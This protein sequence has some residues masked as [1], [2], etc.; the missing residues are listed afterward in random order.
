MGLGKQSNISHKQCVC[1][2]D[3]HDKNMF[4][5]FPQWVSLTLIGLSTN[6]KEA[7]WMGHW[8]DPLSRTSVAWKTATNMC[9]D[10]KSEAKQSPADKSFLSVSLRSFGGALACHCHRKLQHINVYKEF[11]NVDWNALAFKS[12]KFSDLIMHVWLW[13]TDSPAIQYSWGS[14]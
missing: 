14:I 6:Q 3:T 9:G 4:Q 2:I 11:D 13:T 8:T 12:F 10:N 1:W 7:A 5:I